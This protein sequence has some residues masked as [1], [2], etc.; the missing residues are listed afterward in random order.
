MSYH[1]LLVLV[2]RAVF[3]AGCTNR[4][5]DGVDDGK[6]EVDTAAEFGDADGPYLGN[7]DATNGASRGSKVEATGTMRGGEDLNIPC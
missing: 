6:E 7:D 4:H 1:A 2:T 5:A 3:G